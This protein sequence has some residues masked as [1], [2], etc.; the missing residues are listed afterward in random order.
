MVGRYYQEIHNVKAHVISLYVVIGILS[1]V[2]ILTL[3][4]WNNAP[5]QIRVYIPPDLRSAGVF[6]VGEVPG[7]TVYTFAH[8]IFQ[9]LNT[10]RDDG[11]TDYAKNIFDLRAYMTPGFQSLI[12]KDLNSRG[13]RG[14]L[15]NRTRFV[16]EVAGHGFSNERLQVVSKDRWVVWLDFEVKELVNKVTVKETY[17]R[18][19]LKVVRYNVDPEKNPWGLAIDGFAEAPRRLTEE[20]IYAGA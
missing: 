4:G 13:S 5:K 18:Y 20:E 2:L 9:Q 3:L 16:Q 7:S 8:Y 6:E 11:R 1:V 10:W 12:Q 15:S 14:E 17:I 19:A